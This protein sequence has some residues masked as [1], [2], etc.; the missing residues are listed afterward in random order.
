MADTTYAALI[1][2]QKP[3]FSDK[4]V[5]LVRYEG[6]DSYEFPRIVLDKSEQTIGAFHRCIS[7]LFGGTLVTGVGLLGS[8]SFPAKK[9]GQHDSIVYYRGTIDALLHA[10]SSAV[11]SFAFIPY[12]QDDALEGYALGKCVRQVIKLLK[13]KDV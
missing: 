12:Y 2:Q 3:A 13:E 7:D 10:P 5:V 4:R 11:T 6:S 8:K 9:P 1:I